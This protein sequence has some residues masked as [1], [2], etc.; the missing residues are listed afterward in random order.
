MAV[1][2]QS[3]VRVVSPPTNSVTT[4]INSYQVQFVGPDMTFGDELW[5][6]QPINGTLQRTCFANG[7]WTEIL[8]FTID[9]SQFVGTGAVPPTEVVTLTGDVVG[10][11]T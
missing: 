2:I 7:T 9:Q 6:T 11:S 3:S 4:E 1:S 8:S 5:I 10:S